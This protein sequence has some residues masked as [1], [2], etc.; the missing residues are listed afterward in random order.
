MMV[1]EK[2]ATNTGLT[3]TADEDNVSFDKDHSGLVKYES[4]YDQEYRIVKEKVQSLAAKAIT[5]I[6]KRFAAEK[7]M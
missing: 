2:S 4:R 3:A 6:E 1:T 5:N 7:G